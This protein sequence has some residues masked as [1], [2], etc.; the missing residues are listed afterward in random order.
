MYN[1]LILPYIQRR[2]CKG[3][4]ASSVECYINDHN[5]TGEVAIERIETLLE[6]QWRT[7]NQAR[8][9]NHALLPAVQRIIGLALSATF[10]YDNK[11]DVYTL[12]THLR[13]TVEGLFLKPV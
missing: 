8:F 11:N 5:V 7:L 6:H 3:D 12:S 2:K 1:N 13:K 4:A 10:F 9:E